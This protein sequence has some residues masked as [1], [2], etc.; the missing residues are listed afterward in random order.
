MFFINDIFKAV[1]LCMNSVPQE[2]WS[3][4]LYQ[5]SIGFKYVHVD[6]MMCRLNFNSEEIVHEDL[7]LRYT[8]SRV[9]A[10]Q[11]VAGWGAALLQ[12]IPKT[13]AVV[14]QLPLHELETMKRRT[15]KQHW[16]IIRYIMLHH[17]TCY[18]NAFVIGLNVYF[19]DE[20]TN[21]MSSLLIR[22]LRN[23][24]FTQRIIEWPGSL[25]QCLSNSAPTVTSTKHWF[26]YRTLDICMYQIVYTN[27]PTHA[28]IYNM[29]MYRNNYA[30]YIYAVCIYICRLYMYD[31]IKDVLISGGLLGLKAW[32]T[33]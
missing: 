6:H 2:S 10:A 29:C 23:N 9:V 18:A 26:C 3:V 28:Y 8:R 30:L 27:T 12:A 25:P 5:T 14:R 15:K 31:H 33:M 22:T 7:P 20:R 11:L 16:K 24:N 21:N 32:T 4:L 17:R 13:P 19:E 1:L